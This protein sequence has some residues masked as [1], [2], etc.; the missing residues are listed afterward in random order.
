MD[1]MHMFAYTKIQFGCIKP[2]TDPEDLQWP[3]RS[4]VQ[5]INYI[6]TKGAM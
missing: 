1:N 3:S 2:E 5:N 4:G 6:S